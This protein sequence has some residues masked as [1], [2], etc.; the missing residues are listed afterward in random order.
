MV[1]AIIQACA[2]IAVSRSVALQA[3]EL[4]LDQPAISA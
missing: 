3:L 1:R 2:R 4:K